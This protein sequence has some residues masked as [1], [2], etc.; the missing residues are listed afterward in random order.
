[1]I[2]RIQKKLLI[3]YFKIIKGWKNKKMNLFRPLKN[4]QN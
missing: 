4:S 1:M 2:Q 3:N